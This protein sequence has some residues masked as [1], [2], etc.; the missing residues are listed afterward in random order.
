MTF[1]PI[2]FIHCADL[3]LDSRME[4]QLTHFQAQ[5]RR[6]ELLQ[7]FY[8]MVQYAV[9]HQVRAILISGDFFDTSH[10]SDKVIRAVLH[11]IE[12]SPD[13]DFLY[14][15]GNH[16]WQLEALSR[17]HDLPD[18]FYMLRTSSTILPADTEASADSPYFLQPEYAV[19]AIPQRQYGPVVVTG[20]DQI[21]DYLPSLPESSINIVMV[22]GLVGSYGSSRDMDGTIYYAL[23]DLKGRHIDYI[24]AGHLHQFQY[25]SLDSRGIYCYSGCLEGRGF[26]ECGEKGFV[27]LTIDPSALQ[28][29]TEGISPVHFQFVPFSSR[30]LYEKRIDLTTCTDHMQIE[31]L[32]DSAL[33]SID[34]RH[35]VKLILEGQLPL[36]VELHTDWLR[37]KY[38]DDFYYFKLEDHTKTLISYEDYQYDHSL[39]GEF[40]R[41]VL[42]A[43]QL[44]DTEKEAVILEGLHALSGEEILIH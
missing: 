32:I 40:I 2:R 35:L 4:S 5:E 8:R 26:D 10:A 37:Q 11:T 43:P 20:L 31:S 24:A 44:S 7:T 42:S 22:H 9:Q 6:Q 34:N 39:R 13:I 12:S 3:H 33:L 27:L 21:P 18:N 17:R 38:Q 28:P 16:D 25:D 23:Q 14:L 29:E 41:M 15:P 19:T 30:S 36:Q 1:E